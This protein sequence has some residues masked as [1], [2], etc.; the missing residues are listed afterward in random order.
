[1]SQTEKRQQI[2]ALLTEWILSIKSDI[3][4]ESYSPNPMVDA[5]DDLIADGKKRL[6]KLR[7]I[8]E[9]MEDL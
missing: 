2:C 6:V 5:S 1:M 9:Q 8:R 4:H 7:A 3:E